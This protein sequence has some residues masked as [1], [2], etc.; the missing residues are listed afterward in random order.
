MIA[1]SRSHLPLCIVQRTDEI[2]SARYIPVTITWWL[3][4]LLPPK[5]NDILEVL[6]GSPRDATNK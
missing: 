5:L 1:Q 3:V 6:A 4:P 2:L